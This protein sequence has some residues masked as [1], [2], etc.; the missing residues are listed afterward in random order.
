MSHGV[1]Y[2]MAGAGPGTGRRSVRFHEELAAKI[3]KKKPVIAYVGACADDNVGFEKMLGA[4]VFGLTAKLVPVRLSKKALATSEAKAKLED[5]DLVFFSGGD[6]HAGMTII[7]DR[8][9]AKFF[10]D[11]NA[12]G[13]PMEGVSAGSILLGQKWVLFPDD[14]G[15]HRE[16]E[17]FDCLGVVPRS[18]DAHGEADNW[19][20]LHVLAKLLPADDWV[21]GLVSGTC[22]VWKTGELVARGGA[23]HRFKTATA[24]KLPDLAPGE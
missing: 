5:A 3:G 1:V 24:H 13:K 8:G 20:E 10:R 22:G 23:L 7:H 19:E 21:C 16:P 12:S 6:V 11:L 18:F 17:L 9:M 15:G 2:L 4:L 14:E